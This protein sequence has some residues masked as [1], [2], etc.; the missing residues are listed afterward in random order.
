M[1]NLLLVLAIGASL[2]VGG[3]AHQKNLTQEQ[4]LSKYPAVASLKTGLDQAALDQ[5]PLL[6]PQNAEQAKSLYQDAYKL[7]QVDD[8]EAETLASQGLSA[9]ERATKNAARTRIELEAALRARGKARQIQAH[10][11]NK[12]QF[13]NA[14]KEFTKTAKLIEDGK[15]ARAREARKELATL[16]SKLELST[17]K[18]STIEVAASTIKQARKND[19]D[20][21]APKTMAEAEEQLTLAQKVLEADRSAVAK[22]SEH[23]GRAV[24]LADRAT[25]IAQLLIEFDQARMS[26]EEIA[27]WYQEQLSKVVASVEPNPAFNLSNRELVANLQQRVGST[28]RENRQL[29]SQ[30]DSLKQKYSG[31][32]AEKETALASVIAEKETALANIRQTSAAERQAKAEFEAKFTQIQKYF[33]SSEAEV[34]RQGN[35][36]LIRAYGFTFPS[37][38]SEIQSD[39]FPLLNKINSSINQFPSANIVVSGHTD[40]RGST[41]LNQR[42][43][44]QRAQKVARFLVDVGGLPSSRVKAEGM[45]KNRPVASNETSEGRAANRRVEILINNS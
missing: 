1:K 41:E 8:G 35:N 7:A 23:A 31:V 16:Y 4:A 5:V 9:L 19:V 38:S 28:V 42:L 3:C 24:W 44:E 37:G 12:E 33:S 34:Y 10:T 36:V 45:G 18:G 22:A 30:I 2:L 40:S 17:L 25:Q 43:S 20:D 26:N 11:R 15:I 27:L 13:A 39:N 21:Y 6:S 14:D 32:I 29:A